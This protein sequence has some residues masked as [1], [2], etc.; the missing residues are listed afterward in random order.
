MSLKR[1]LYISGPMTGLPEF[2]FPAFAQ[3]AD[4][5][6]TLGCDVLSA[7]EVKH[8]EPNGLGSLP[9]HE[10]LRADLIAMLTECDEIVMLPGWQNS[11]GATLERHVAMALG[12][13]VHH[14][15]QA[16]MVAV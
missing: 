4:W 14:Y 6:R 16:E 10:Y 13:P 11:K 1:K 8:D 2:N 12:F 15:A 3:A 5:Y 9:W 7:H